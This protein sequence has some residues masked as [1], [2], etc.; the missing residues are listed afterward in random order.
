MKNSYRVTSYD[1]PDLTDWYD[2]SSGTVSVTL[3]DR[4]ER[5]GSD[6]QVNDDT[7]NDWSHHIVRVYIYLPSASL[8]ILKRLSVMLA[9]LAILCRKRVELNIDSVESTR[10]LTT[11]V[12]LYT[13]SRIVHLKTVTTINDTETYLAPQ[14]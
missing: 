2:Y 1:L 10:I 8:L 14:E 5:G 11:A 4:A 7:V 9:I 13:S 12:P 6:F 3:I